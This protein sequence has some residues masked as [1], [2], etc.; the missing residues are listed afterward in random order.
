MGVPM[1]SFLSNVRLTR[2]GSAIE[3]DV[4]GIFILF[5]FVRYSYYASRI[6]R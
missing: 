4:M 6:D 1:M 5:V 3:T 2:L